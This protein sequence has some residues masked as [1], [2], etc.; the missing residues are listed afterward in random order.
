MTTETLTRPAQWPGL[1][2]AEGKRWHYLDS[3][4][5]AQK[6]QAVIDATVAAMGR[7]YATVHRGVYTRS[8]EMT[9]AYEAA[10]RKVAGLIGGAENELVFTRGAT[11]AINLVAQ[12]WGIANLRPGDRVLLSQLEHHSNIVPWQLI[13]DRTGIGIDVCPLTADG[14]IDLDAAEAMLTPAHKLVAFAH[15][16]N[17]LGSVLDAPRAVALAHGVGAKILLDGC[18]AAARLPVDVKALGCDFYAFSGHKLYG[19]TGIGALWARAE[20]LEAMP[21]WQ[22]GGSMI[23]RVTFAATT[24]APPPQRFEAGTP[25]IIEALALGAAVDFM[26]SVGLDAIRAHE[27]A[28]VAHLRGELARLNSV[29]LFGPE[30]SAGIVSFALEGVHPHDLG[31]ILDE[32]NVAIRAGHHCAQPLMAHLGVPATARASFG[33]YSDESD[34][35]ALLRGIERTMRIFG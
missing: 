11:E 1:F 15:V 29:T 19:P 12:S 2:N 24:W 28:L 26:G 27:S 20:I 34:I 4:A 13:R 33:I 5:T 23:D 9:L 25:A 30:D 32:E 7:D 6:P 35:A 10:R 17:V 14:R 18:Q 31:T 8:A 3:A 16:S 21:P 22:G